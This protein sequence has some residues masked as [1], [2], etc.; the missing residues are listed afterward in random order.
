MRPASCCR[1][2]RRS[3]PSATPACNR[4]SCPRPISPRPCSRTTKSS[5]CIRSINYAYITDAQEGLI[6]T[7]VDTLQDGEPR[8]NFLTRALTWNEGGILD[9]ARHLTIAGTHFYV[10]ADK[11]IVELDMD[12][13]L[14]PKVMA[15][16]PIAGAN[17]SYLQFRYL[18]VVGS[19]GFD[20]VDV[21]DPMQPVVLPGA[22]MA[23]DHATRVTVTRTYAYVADGPDGIAIIDVE[24]PDHPKL[25]MQYTADGALKDVRDVAIGAT[26][27]SLFAYVAD[28]AAGLKVIQLMSPETQPDFLRL[29]ARPEARAHRLVQDRIACAR[30]VARAR[31]RPRRRRDRAPDRRLRPYRLAP[32]RRRRDEEILPRPRRQALHRERQGEDGG[33]RPGHAR[34]RRPGRASDACEKLN[35]RFLTSKFVAARR[36]RQG[37]GRGVRC[38]WCRRRRSSASHRL[39]SAMP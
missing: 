27:A 8:N 4:R 20:V 3:I 11:G 36:L 34:T 10:S 5:R 1:R 18:F 9:G 35:H 37:R 13:P 12:D 28:G 23:L 15:V 17:A 32:V 24:R 2:I 31:A 6:L 21:T 30:T 7:N 39:A 22:H 33:F 14:H 25:Y 16:I 26:N 38:R 29:L 19:G